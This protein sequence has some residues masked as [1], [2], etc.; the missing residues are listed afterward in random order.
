MPRPAVL[1]LALLLLGGAPLSQ[2]LSSPAPSDAGET[3]FEAMD[4][5]PVGRSC[6]VHPSIEVEGDVGATGLLLGYA[7]EGT[8]IYR[9]G[10]GVTSGRGTPE[11]PLVIRRLCIHGDAEKPAVRISN[12]TLAIAIRELDLTS[13]LT[14]GTIILKNVGDV[15]LRH[16]L[17]ASG[18][19]VTN[20]RSVTLAGGLGRSLGVAFADRVVAA[21]LDATPT[22]VEDTDVVEVRDSVA[23]IEV[24]RAGHV[25]IERHQGPVDL[26]VVSGFLARNVS[27][28]HFEITRSGRGL[29]E[30]LSA[31][32]VWSS[33]SHN[34]T[35]GRFRV[36]GDRIFLLKVNDSIFRDGRVETVEGRYA[37]IDMTG[38]RNLVERTVF[39]NARA[40][41][42]LDGGGHNV[43]R[44]NVFNTTV[45]IEVQA[46]TENVIDRNTLPRRGIEFTEKTVASLAQRIGDGNTEDGAPLRYVRGLSNAV[47]SGGEGR[48]IVF[49]STQTTIA[50][51]TWPVLLAHSSKMLVT[52]S[53]APVHALGTTSSVFSR[54]DHAGTGSIFLEGSRG[55]LIEHNTIDAVGDLCTAIRLY[56]SPQNRIQNNTVNGCSIGILYE[57]SQE[58][59]IRHNN[60]S[61]ASRHGIRG[62]LGSGTTGTHIHANNIM[63]N[64]EGVSLQ[65]AD[66]DTLKNNFRG[67][68][69]A[70]NST[71]NANARDNWWGCP[72]G[73]GTPGC[74]LVAPRV[75]LLSPWRTAPN[76]AAGRQS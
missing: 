25:A 12:V 60:I 21:G 65:Q 47:I 72:T 26:D 57:S 44:D 38:S 61:N 23:S 29:V 53:P 13:D 45:G 64:V 42:I 50:D 18:V 67:N 55:N 37:G 14:R 56:G 46:S 10:S 75:T 19:T 9:P 62:I 30:D 27:T 70:I 28:S 51:Q 76:P 49:G 43:V 63:D 68:V 48:L 54:N 41:I 2:G 39:L 22:T 20:A 7:P 16:L 8:P 4:S 36:G 11:D 32:E 5:L 3:I 35:F 69:L 52:R 66:T 58:V 71:T 6:I 73:P 1:A 34:L 59:A 33:N 15:D 24:R 40:G 17:S 31:T 74:D